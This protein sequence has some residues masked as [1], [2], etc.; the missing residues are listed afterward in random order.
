MSAPDKDLPPGWA[1]APLREIGTWTGGGTPSKRNPAFWTDGTIPWVSPKDMKT[2]LLAQAEDSITER[3]LEESSAKRIE[4][5]SVLFVT[6]SGI[7]RHT[8]PVAVNRVDVTVNQDL[9]A[10]TPAD[11]VEPAYLLRFVQAAN[12]EMLHETVKDGTTVQSVRTKK[13]YDYPVPLAPTAEQRRIVDAIEAAFAELDAGVAAIE[14]A[15]RD[16]DRYRRSVLTA[17]VQ[18]DLTA[19]WRRQHPDAEPASALLERVEA[20]RRER[21]EAD[22]LA[23]YQAKGKTP[24]KNWRQRYK[25]PVEPEGEGLSNLPPGWARASMDALS[26]QSSYGTSTKCTYESGGPPV[27]RIPNIDDGEIDLADMKHAAS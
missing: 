3:A 2:D 12:R 9:K 15:R 19:D 7:L 4:A 11:G 18:G 26:W 13:L 14:A 8:L 10:L 27:L 20:E 23:A 5:G 21:W 25:P 22:Q 1:R 24:P 16:L 17:A 6:R